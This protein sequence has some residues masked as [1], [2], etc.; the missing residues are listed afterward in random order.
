MSFLRSSCGRV[1]LGASQAF[2]PAPDVVQPLQLSL[3]QA[4]VSVGIPRI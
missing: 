4:S 3:I 2:G 1:V